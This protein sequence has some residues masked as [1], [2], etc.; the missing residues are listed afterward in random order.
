MIN[1]RQ[2]KMERITNLKKLMN[3]IF[4]RTKERRNL[5]IIFDK[6]MKE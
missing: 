5:L 6:K 4:Y 3:P 1:K 2:M